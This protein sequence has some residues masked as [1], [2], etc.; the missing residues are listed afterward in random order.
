ML[1]YAIASL[2]SVFLP[3]FKKQVSQPQPYGHLKADTLLWEAVLCTAGCLAHLWSLL[4]T[5]EE[6]QPPS[7][8]NYRQLQ[9]PPVSSGGQNH[10]CKVSAT[11]LFSPLLLSPPPFNQHPRQSR[12]KRLLLSSSLVDHHLRQAGWPRM[13]EAADLGTEFL[14]QIPLGPQASSLPVAWGVLT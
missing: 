5:Y 11:L 13:Q 4:S 2:P 10:S 1:L 8:D 7:C 3:F 6:C 14:L 12:K 9:T